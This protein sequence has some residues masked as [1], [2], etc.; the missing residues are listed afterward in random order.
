MRPDDAP[1]G[2]MILS[3]LIAL[4]ASS[5]VCWLIILTEGMH[6]RHTADTTG[7]SPQKINPLVVPRV[8]GL[9]IL[10]GL[11]AGAYM[12]TQK[13]GDSQWWAV[14]ILASLPAFAGGMIEDL[15]K[16]FSVYSRLLTTFIAAGFGFFLLDARISEL[17]LPGV[18]L[19]LGFTLVS[20]IFTLLAIGGFAH[21][22][23]IIDG[24]N[25]L[26]GGVCVLML[27]G[28]AAVSLQ[29]GDLLVFHASVVLGGAIVGFLLLNFP[30]GL[31]FAGDAGAYLMGFLIAE[32]AVIL[33]HRNSEVSPWFALLLLFYPVWETLFSAFRRKFIAGSSP[34]APDALHM[35]T[36]IYRRLIRRMGGERTTRALTA[37]N[38]MTAPYLWFL[39]AL[40][41]FP[42]AIFWDRSAILQSVVVAFAVLY[43]WLYRR[44]IRFRTPKMLIVAS[45]PDTVVHALGQNKN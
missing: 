19:M 20:F 21:A 3:C 9:A 30:R 45:H 8:G 12:S 25:G 14:F 2:L 42:A 34:G 24:F 22:T 33:V 11:V 41:V 18:D 40:T 36:L 23:N 38:A 10:A 32:L 5:L 35:H 43:V 7:G 44:I 1:K 15:T 29:V 31:I 28:L 6:G 16:R 37:R 26:S 4:L 13:F 17:Q 39:A 27:A